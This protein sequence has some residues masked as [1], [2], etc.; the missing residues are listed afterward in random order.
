MTS[1]TSFEKKGKKVSMIS[2]G[3]FWIS[4][5]SCLSQTPKQPIF[6]SAPGS[7]VAM[8]CGPGNIVASD[9]NNDNKPDLIITCG[10]TRTLTIYTGKG[11][12]RFETSA[13]S[14][15]TMREAP[16]EIVVS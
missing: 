16:N 2:T 5:C 14:R 15:L 4:C 13:R 10:Q 9:L 1:T 7:P 3:I 8:N 6:E 11:G 12:G